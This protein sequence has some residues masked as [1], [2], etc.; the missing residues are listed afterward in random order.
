MIH[1]LYIM[2]NLGEVIELSLPLEDDGG[3]EPKENTSN[4]GQ[5]VVSVELSWQEDC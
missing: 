1:A 4:I 5:C 3:E 2:I